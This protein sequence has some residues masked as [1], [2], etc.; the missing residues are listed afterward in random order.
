MKIPKEAKLVFKGVIYNVYQWQQ[1]MLDGSFQTFEAVDRPNSVIVL[2]TRNNKLLIAKETQ[3][4]KGTFWG[5][6]GGQIEEGETP[7]NAAKRELQEET[8]LESKD[9]EK[10]FH[11]DM[12]GMQWRLTYYAAR[13]CQAT[14]RSKENKTNDPG[15][16]I[17]I[18]EI[19]FKDLPIY[20][21]KDNWRDKLLRY[22]FLSNIDKK[23]L[24]NLK[25]KLKL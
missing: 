21:T 23:E 20:L 15:E 7:L 24:N 10:L 12:P 9:W 4:F 18:H 3:P 11:Y 14:T 22:T 13:D 6:F 5:F 25:E 16:K 2:P 8:G 19:N 17:E 1:K